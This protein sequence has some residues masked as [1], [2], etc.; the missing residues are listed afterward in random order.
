MLIVSNEN[1]ISF[2]VEMVFNMLGPPGKPPIN[3]VVLYGEY[4][5]DGLERDIRN[6]EQLCKTFGYDFAKSYIQSTYFLEKRRIL[7]NYIECF[8]E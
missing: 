7:L 2:P 1:I 3:I 6:V 8:K 4:P 5:N